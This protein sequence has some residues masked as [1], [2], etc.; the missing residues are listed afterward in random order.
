MGD[1]GFGSKGLGTRDP[2]SRLVTVLTVLSVS[3]TSGSSPGTVQRRTRS[4][5]GHTHFHTRLTLRRVH[6]VTDPERLDPGDHSV[7]T[8]RRSRPGVRCLSYTVTRRNHTPED[9]REI[10]L[11]TRKMITQ[12]P[13]KQKNKQTSTG[14]PTQGAPIP[15]RSV[16]RSW[17]RGHLRTRRVKHSSRRVDP[18]SRVGLLSIVTG[19]RDHRGGPPVD[20][21]KTVED[22]SDSPDCPE[23]RLPIDHSGI[24]RTAGRDGRGECVNQDGI[25]PDS[26]TEESLVDRTTF[27]STSHSNPSYPVDETPRTWTIPSQDYTSQ[28]TS[29]CEDQD[30]K[31]GTT[32]KRVDGQREDEETDD[33]FGTGKRLPFRP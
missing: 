28:G 33:E 1:E 9:V 17:N 16:R 20:S 24:E 6:P 27:S 31:T 32:R 18:P 25:R 2:E 3:E 7:L 10:L 21:P 26:F 4:R 15:L 23:K 11:V 5:S 29:G 19:W 14:Y 12:K 8:T 22:V 30:R 13:E